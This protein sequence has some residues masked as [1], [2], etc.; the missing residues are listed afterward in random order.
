MANRFE[1]ELSVALDG[2]K[3]AA[4]LCQSV[5]GEITDEVLS[6]KD[7]SPV[8]V[9]DFGSQAIVCRAIC[10]A[11]P[12][13]EIIAEE[14][15]AEL[16]QSENAPFRARIREELA[17]VGIDAAE[18]EF[19]RWIDHG[20]AHGRADRF[21]TLDPIDGTKGFVRREQYAVSLA[22]I[23]GGRIEVGLLAC[24]NLPFDEA[25]RGAIFAAVRGQGTR[26]YP[27]EG[28]RAPRVVRVSAVSDPTQS[29]FCESVESA[30]SSHGLAAR[31]GEQ[32]GITREPLRLDS[33]A[34]YAVVARGEAEVYMRLP[35]KVGYKEKIWDHAGGVLVVEE[36]GGRVTDLDNKPLEFTHGAELLANR[37]IIAGNPAMHAAVLGALQ[38]LVPELQPRP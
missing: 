29:R 35:T 11:F 15:S 21:W 6:K 4:R 23:I 37:G 26:V 27:L 31:V 30:H 13:D 1:K 17:K 32:L 3:L 2:L 24:P 28:N 33:Q 38:T 20:N 10:G 16:Q 36:A 34:K 8:T 19:C 7:K 14:D 9:A 18:S 12:N 5:Q 25:S 22:L